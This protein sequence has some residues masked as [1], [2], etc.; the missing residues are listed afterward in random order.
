MS[1]IFDREIGFWKEQKDE[2]DFVVT[3]II[4]TPDTIFFR[5]VVD[6]WSSSWIEDE[7]TFNKFPAKYRVMSGGW[8]GDGGRWRTLKRFVR[9]VKCEGAS[10]YAE[11]SEAGEHLVTFHKKAL[12][13]KIEVT[14][15]SEKLGL[16]SFKCKDIN[17]TEYYEMY[18][19]DNQL[20]DFVEATA[21]YPNPVTFVG[22][23]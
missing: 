22:K 3:K 4:K 2:I 23:L 15:T 7:E 5:Y 13:K 11:T 14:I 12:S 9:E 1:K 8:Y 21:L 6:E 20:G 17:L 16:V 10:R 18:V 19:F